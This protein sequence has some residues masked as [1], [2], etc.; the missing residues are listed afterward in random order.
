MR[1]FWFHYNRPASL[2][3]G[4]PQ[5]SVHYQGTCHIVDNVVC[6]RPTTGKINKRQPYFVM[7]GLCN[8]VTIQ[9]GVAIIT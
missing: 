4:K 9:K 6:D 5:V 7:R 3:A 2:R 8:N 1:V